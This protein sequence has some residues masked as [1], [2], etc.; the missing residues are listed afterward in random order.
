MNGLYSRALAVWGL[1]LLARG[2]FLVVDRRAETLKK[3]NVRGLIT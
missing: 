2:P 1:T 3:Y